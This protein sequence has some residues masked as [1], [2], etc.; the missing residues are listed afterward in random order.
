MLLPDGKSVVTLKQLGFDC[1]DI[2]DVIKIDTEARSRAEREATSGRYVTRELDKLIVD[3]PVIHPVCD[4]ICLG[5]NYIE[6]AKEAAAYHKDTYE[7][8]EAAVYFSKHADRVS[9]WNSVIPYDPELTGKIDYEAELAVI[10]GRDCKNVHRDKVQDHIF[11][12]TIINDVSARDVQSRHKQ[13]YLGKSLDGY[14]P[15]GPCVLTSDEVDFPP[16]L[17]IKSWVNGELRQNSTT[18]MMIH[19][20][21]EIICELSRYM[22]LRAG[23]VIS[24]G[25]PSGVGMGLKPPQF[26]NKGDVI[27][28]EIEKIGALRN[29]VY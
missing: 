27:V 7:E 28:C 5:L 18:D 15:M 22:T 9:A 12:Y 21:D 8:T 1:A 2:L 16:K 25:T 24:T 26:L 4:T 3:A 23:T 29:L 13:W 20:I 11:G 17:H 14:L 19:G 6:H 10:I